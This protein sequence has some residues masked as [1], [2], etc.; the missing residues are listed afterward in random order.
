MLKIKWIKGLSENL[1][2]QCD[3]VIDFLIE[4]LESIKK[5]YS[6]T[7][8]SLQNEISQTKKTLSGLMDELVANEFDKK[9]IEE[10]Q[11]ILRG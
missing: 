3:D 2:K 11:K 9:G 5:K 6:I 7:Y 8:E 10:F 4:K 1:E